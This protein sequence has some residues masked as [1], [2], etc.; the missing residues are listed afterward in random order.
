[1]SKLNPQISVVEVG[2]K[3]TREVTIYPLSL[4]DQ[5]KTARILAKAFQEVMGKLASFGDEDEDEGSGK[6]DLIS[7]AKQ[8][9][10]IDIVEFILSSIQ[11]NLEVILELV[12]DVGEKI[13]MEELTN[14]QFYTLAE[15]IYEV[16]YE[17][18]S[19]NFLALWKRALGERVAEIKS[20]KKVRRKVSHSTKPSPGSV[21]GT[22]I[23]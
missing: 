15:M 4:A 18:T 7:M 16:N 17:R 23:D 12:V 9:S 20:E 8:L 11:E 1:M 21:D 10:D 19:K 13:S 6:E 14:E 5:A 3:S 22:T 2:T